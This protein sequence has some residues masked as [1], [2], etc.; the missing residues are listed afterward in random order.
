MATCTPSVPNSWDSSG[1]DCRGSPRTRTSRVVHVRR[2]PVS[3]LPPAP[4]RRLL[5][6]EDDEGGERAGR[7]RYRLESLDGDLVEPESIRATHT[8]AGALERYLSA[9]LKRRQR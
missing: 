1:E 5:V 7:R 8:G 2:I 6:P 9:D 3:G 4:A